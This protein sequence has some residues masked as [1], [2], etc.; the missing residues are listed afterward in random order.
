MIGLGHCRLAINDLRPSAAQPMHSS[1]GKIHAVVI[2][3]IYDFYR[4]RAELSWKFQYK[5]QTDSDSEVALVLYQHHGLD[6]CQYLRGEFAIC[7]YDE[8][9]RRF[10]AVRDRFG[11]KPL[12]WTVSNDRL[13]IA[14]EIKAFIAFGWQPEWDVASIVEF[15]WMFDDRTVFQDVTKLMPGQYL[16]C[17]EAGSLKL[18]TYWEINYPDKVCSSH[19]KVRRNSPSFVSVKSTIDVTKK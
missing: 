13:L 9:R 10:L 3:E 18:G 7:I 11:I 14:A 19:G 16:I 17:D 1:C 2:G 4:I 12:F 8:H 15:G 5:F 6:F